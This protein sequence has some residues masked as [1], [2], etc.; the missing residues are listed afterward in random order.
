MRL[1][2]FVVL[3]TV[4]AS[5][6]AADV[7]VKPQEKPIDPANFDPSVK[8]WDDFYEYANG[9]WL[10]ANPIPPEYSAWGA[11][12]EL[13]ER[14]NAALRKELEAA[15]AVKDAKPGSPEQLVGD[16]YA[17]GMDE[18]AIEKAGIEPL[19]D[20]FAR[21]AAID[22]PEALARTMAH[23]TERGV[24]AGFYF[25]S[26]QDAKDSESVI[27]QLYQAGIGL[28]EREYY[29]EPGEEAEKL[30]AAYVAHVART[31]ELLGDP[32]EKAED[33]AQ[34]VM[35][36]E[37]KLA[38]ASMPNVELRDPDATYHKMTP[39]ELRELMPNFAWD[40]YFDAVGMKDP[41]AVNVG[42]PKFFGAFDAL[43]K[44]VSVEDWQAYLRWHLTSAASQFLGE[45]FVN[46]W[47]DFYARTLNGNE[48]LKPRWKRVMAAIDDSVG[49]ALGQ[50]YVQEN[51]P[52][53]AKEQALHLVDNLREALKERIEALPWMGAETKKA[54]LRKLAAMT[55]KIGYP[56]VWKDYAG[57]KIDRGPYVGNVFR[58]NA[59]E[60]QRD[61]AKIGKPVDR[62]EWEMSPPTVNAYFHPSMNEIVFPAGILQPPFFDPKADDA[63]N[64]G[65]IGAVIGH[66]LTHGFDD[67]GRKY[68]EKGN[69]ENWWTADDLKNFQGRAQ[70]I[71][72]QFDAYEVLDG[73]NVN[74]RLT[75]GE[76][77]ADLG[78]AKI[79]YAALQ[80]ALAEKP[81]P[82]E[83]EGF[84][85]AQRFFLSYAQTWRTNE[86]DESI[87]VQVKTDPH[88]PAEFRVNGPLS[89]LEEFAEAFECPPDSPM[90][91]KERVEI[92]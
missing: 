48:E 40:A 81:A 91:R 9:G 16:F 67:Q 8:P 65:G 13:H 92:W 43:V 21:I 64:Y 4:A 28:P 60:F 20:D 53:E 72:D 15:A 6:F 47:F 84:T 24:D 19:A 26:G 45:K 63:V 44:D 87:R 42:Q 66:E 35:A 2:A 89:N 41:G 54:A 25:G 5:I 3:S 36:L 1:S 77:I 83:I 82:D 22:G 29:R 32:K 14:N 88:S 38:E 59:F 50:L 76:N 68:D 11:F 27:A 33:A 56:D 70:K 10:K 49:E 78:G 58:S 18:A 90:V 46:E 12:H 75:T 57:L 74:G 51:F 30:R 61:L 80:K 73:L 23:L 79:A 17:S 34:R 62:N 86:R 69:L 39:V 55:V 52:P 85:P 7:V 71:I 31:F 37:T